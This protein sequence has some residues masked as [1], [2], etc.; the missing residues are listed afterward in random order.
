MNHPLARLPSLDLLRGFVAVARRMS[1]TQA[2]ADLFL[3]QSA[4]SRQVRTLVAASL[5]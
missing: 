5:G 3:T 4:V 1:V 2:A